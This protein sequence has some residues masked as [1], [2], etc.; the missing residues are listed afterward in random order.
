MTWVLC[1]MCGC[2]DTENNVISC[3]WDAYQYLLCC[4]CIYL[5]SP[6]GQPCQPGSSPDHSIKIFQPALRGSLGWRLQLAWRLLSCLAEAGVQS[7]SL[8]II[9][10]CLLTEAGGQWSSLNIHGTFVPI[11]DSNVLYR[12]RQVHYKSL[13][14]DP[15]LVLTHYKSLTRVPSLVL[16]VLLHRPS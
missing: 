11:I 14:R 6:A 16:T 1:L 15:S 4:Y 5:T 13:T 3:K 10:R 2:C 9:V 12:A 7:L 8:S